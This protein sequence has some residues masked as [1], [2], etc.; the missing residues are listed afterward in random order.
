MRAHFFT[1]FY[2]VH[3]DVVEVE[4]AAP[5]VLVEVEAAVPTLVEAE[6]VVAPSVLVEVVEAVHDDDNMDRQLQ[7]QV[8]H[9]PIPLDELVHTQ[10]L[11]VVVEHKH[12]LPL[13]QA[14]LLL[15]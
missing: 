8:L 11:E 7:S 10:V 2:V 6:E 15:G 3:H 12:L 1:T 13:P 5:N 9:L 4:A 14:L